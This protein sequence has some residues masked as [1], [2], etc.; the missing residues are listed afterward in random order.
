MQEGSLVVNRWQHGT[1]L[2][3]TLRETLS[4]QW[5]FDAYCDD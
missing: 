2:P 4:S 3:F 1:N 5:Y